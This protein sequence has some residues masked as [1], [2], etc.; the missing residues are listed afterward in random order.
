MKICI[1]SSSNTYNNNNK[2]TCEFLLLFYNVWEGG[3]GLPASTIESINKEQKRRRKNAV[4][5][6]NILYL[7][8][9]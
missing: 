5:K 1:L 2:S 4:N 6:E 3:I 8:R 9:L 7:I